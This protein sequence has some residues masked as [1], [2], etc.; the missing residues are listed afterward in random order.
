[1]NE[2]YKTFFDTLTKLDLSIFPID[3]IRNSIKN[4]GF[5]GTSTIIIHP[6][7][8]VMRARKNENGVSF[9]NQKDISYKPSHL[10]NRYYRAS[11]PETTM[12]YGSIIPHKFQLGDIDRLKLTTF[13]ETSSIN[14]SNRL[15][16]EH[17]T[18]GLWTVKEPF[19]LSL[20]AT[21]EDFMAGNPN[22]HNLGEDKVYVI[23]KDIP[24]DIAERNAVL[25]QFYTTEFSKTPIKAECDYLHSALFTEYILSKKISGVYYPSIRTE[26]SA[27]NIA[28]HPEIVESCMLL[29]KAIECK[30]YILDGIALIDN[31]LECKPDINGDLLFKPLNNSNEHFGREKSLKVISDIRQNNYEIL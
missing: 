15:I 21:Q 30:V 28:V 17:F 24:S 19:Q 14:Y 22:L 6:G 31:I 12:F 10:N 23:F 5:A 11:T 29:V 25:S 8:F 9:T 4:I 2:H 7:D 1:M 13:S 16:E 27:F 26:Y 18:F 20:I 3:E